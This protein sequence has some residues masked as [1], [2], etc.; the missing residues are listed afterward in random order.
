M[1]IS[2][3]RNV[4][5]PPQSTSTKIDEPQVGTPGTHVTQ[6]KPAVE[7]GK[8]GKETKPKDDWNCMDHI[9]WMNVFWFTLLHFGA[10]YGAFLALTSASWKTFVFGEYQIN[11]VLV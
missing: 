10:L 3:L 8:T 6:R 5:M 11:R 2:T 7:N 1:I 4:T 9:L